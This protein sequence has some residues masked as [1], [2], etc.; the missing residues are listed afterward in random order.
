MRLQEVLDEAL[1]MLQHPEFKTY[2]ALKKSQYQHE[3]TDDDKFLRSDMYKGIKGNSEAVKKGHITRK[4][5]KNYK[6]DIKKAA[7]TRSDWYKNPENMKK[8]K[9]QLKNRKN[10]KSN[11]K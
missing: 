11:E 9:Q 8:F 2:G 10:N 5:N 4:K 6:E 3:M 7:K 1:E